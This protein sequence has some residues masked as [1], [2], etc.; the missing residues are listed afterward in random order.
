MKRGN[1]TQGEAKAICFIIAN[2]YHGLFQMTNIMQLMKELI[3]YRNRFMHM[4]A[5]LL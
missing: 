1:C 5:D 4:L 2:E 3:V